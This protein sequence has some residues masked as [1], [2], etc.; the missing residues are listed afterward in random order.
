[1]TENEVCA[2]LP[3]S[4][5]AVQLTVEEP[6]GNEEPD[7]GVHAMRQ[8]ASTLSVAVI[9]NGTG[10]CPGVPVA[11]KTVVPD[12][13][14]NTGSTSSTKAVTVTLNWAEPVLPAASVALQ[15]MVVVPT[16]NVSPEASG[17]HVG[18]SGPSTSSSA[19]AE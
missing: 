6:S 2:E 19:L 12:G 1:M 5:V 13:E 7:G 4:S 8:S 14:P 16:G 15:V 3:E 18:V 10:S 11:S 17:M 9:V